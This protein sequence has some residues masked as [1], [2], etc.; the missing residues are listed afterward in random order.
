MAESYSIMVAEAVSSGSAA[1]ATPIPEG[2]EGD[3]V[4]GK[5]VQNI[6]QNIR[7]HQ[8][9]G[10]TMGQQPATPQAQGSA[11]NATSSAPTSSFL[12]PLVTYSYLTHLPQPTSSAY[13]NCR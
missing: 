8:L 13:P 3:N 6:A 12:N 5:V 11:W 9:F 1:A 7:L 10:T 4:T 2:R